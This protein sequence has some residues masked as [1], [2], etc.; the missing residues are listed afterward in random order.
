[1]KISEQNLVTPVYLKTDS[2]FSWPEHES[3]FHLLSSDGLFLCRNHPFF[4]SSTLA[5]DGPSE[6]AGHRSFM[7]LKYPKIPR[8]MFERV[9]GFFDRIGF[10]HGAE[11]AVL[12]AWNRDSEEVELIIPHQQALVGEDYEGRPF[13]I[14][15]W[16]DMP[17]IPDHLKVFGDAHSHVKEPAIASKTD[18]DDDAERPGLHII[19][20][21]IDREPP[22]ICVHV[23]VDGSRF[24]VKNPGSVIEGYRTRCKKNIPEA[25]IKKVNV[26]PWAPNKNTNDLS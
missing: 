9:V 2:S 20:G 22:E 5:T 7:D 23:T 15:V 8:S 12:F 14:N 3:V 1:M 19:V 16:Y 13:P 21:R 24:R 26:I 4:R 17:V 11:A 6:L 10:D 25:W 18:I